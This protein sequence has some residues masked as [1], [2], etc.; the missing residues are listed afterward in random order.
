LFFA[1]R[2]AKKNLEACNRVQTLDPM[3]QA[4]IQGNYEQARAL[5]TDPFMQAEI[6]IQLDC[7]SEAE[8]I[9]RRMAGTEMP[10]KPRTLVMSQ[11]GHLLMLQ[12]QYGEAMDCFQLAL[13]LWPERGSTYRGI[14]EWHLR[15]GDNS[16][17]ALRWARLAVEKE[18]ASPGLSPD[19]KGIC[20]SEDYGVLAWAVAVHSH[21]GAEVDRL[22]E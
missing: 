2:N 11:L 21:D 15:R 4:Y 1:Y 9:L 22:C 14:A 18:K 19:S 5:A 7:P 17:E 13:K 3:T 10:S 12:K 6:L 20:L 8:A 16:A